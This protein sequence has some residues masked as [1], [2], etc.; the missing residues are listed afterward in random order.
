MT[1]LFHSR[2]GNVDISPAFYIGKQLVIQIFFVA[3][4]I[5]I[6][7]CADNPIKKF[8]L[9]RQSFR[10]CLNGNN[11]LITKSHAA[12]KFPVLLRVTPKIGGINLKAIF[13]CKKH[14]G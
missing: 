2:Y 10:I 1:V 12:E 5:I 7:I 6:G 13:L 3:S 8:L 9:K 11:L 14:R 4:E